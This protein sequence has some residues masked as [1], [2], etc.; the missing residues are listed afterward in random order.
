MNVMNYTVI[1]YTPGY[2]PEDDDPPVF[3]Q[4]AEA[5]NYVLV[6]RERLFSDDWGYQ[7]VDAG[8]G[9]VKTLAF[10]LD[11][12]DFEDDGFVYYDKR[13]TYD[14]GRIVQIVPL[15]VCPVCG[16]PDN[17]GDCNHKPATDDEINRSFDAY[18]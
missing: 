14:L 5:V 13:K 10:M 17:C 11:V 7:E 16:Q 12:G 6:E 2:L 8:F 18:R 15:E 3:D 9:Q 1:E 4:W